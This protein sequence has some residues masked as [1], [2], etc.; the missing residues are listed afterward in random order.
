MNLEN[1]SFYT[2]EELTHLGLKSYGKNVLISRNAK[3]YSPNT[4]SIGDNV[5]IDDFCILS[6]HIQLGSHIHISSY[7]ALFGA[8]G[9][10]MEDYTGI[11]SHSIVYSAMDDFSGMFLVGPIHPQGTTHV[12][13]GCVRI[14]KYVQVGANCVIF[15]NLEIGEGSIIGSCSL[16]SHSVGEWGIYFGTPVKWQ[17]ERKRDLLKFIV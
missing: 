16:V 9:I 13:G 3:F 8:L 14:N 7:V 15:P 4:I 1:T 17:K 10:Y 12:T 11:S 6:G 2:E 5:R